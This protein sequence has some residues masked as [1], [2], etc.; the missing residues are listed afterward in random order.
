[1]S[2]KFRAKKYRFISTDKRTTRV[3]YTPQILFNDGWCCFPDHSTESE[4]IEYK[5][6][7]DALKN[8]KELYEHYHAKGQC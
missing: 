7:E 4:L 2:K 6:K 3:I 5:D 1:M 8:A